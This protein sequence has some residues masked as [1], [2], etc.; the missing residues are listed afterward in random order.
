MLIQPQKESEEILLNEALARN[1]QVEY[2]TEFIAM[3]TDE[4]PHKAIIESNSQKNEIPYDYLIGAD[5]GKSRVRKLSDISYDGLQY[6]EEWELYDV[7]LEM[8][9]NRDEGHIRF[10][11]EGSVLMIRLY[12][13]VWRVAGRMDSILNYMP[14]K[15]K[16]GKILWQSKF[17]IHHKIAKKLSWG[18]IGIIGDAAHLH[19]PVG[20]RGMNLGIED[21]YILSNLIHNNNLNMFDEIRRPYITKTVN[22]INNLTMILAGNNKRAEFLRSNLGIIKFIAPLAM[23][24]ARK[25]ILGIN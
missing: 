8:E 18:N 15:S 7:E 24:R 3:K 19:S 14:K 11:P 4:S 17:R 10:F 25:F 21:A 12:D 23:P 20:A 6:D 22:G 16:I 1:I 2:D 9:L 5:G 13:N